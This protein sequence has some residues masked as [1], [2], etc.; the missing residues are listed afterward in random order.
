M[1][2]MSEDKVRTRLREPNG[3][4]KL[5]QAAEEA[6]PAAW[7]L[8]LSGDAQAASFLCRCARRKSFSEKINTE[9]GVS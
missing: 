1:M 9:L 2:P 3:A 5:M 7:R 4:E 6:Y 8:F